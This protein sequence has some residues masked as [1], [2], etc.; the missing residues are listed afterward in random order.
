MYSVPSIHSLTCQV[1]TDSL[2]IAL[3]AIPLTGQVTGALVCTVRLV[4]NYKPYLFTLYI[5]M[6]NYAHRHRNNIIRH[7]RLTLSCTC[8]DAGKSWFLGRKMLFG[9][10]FAAISV[11]TLSILR[12]KIVKVRTQD[13]QSEGARL[14]VLRRK[15]DYLGG[16]QHAFLA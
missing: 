14:T 7:R 6:D 4:F 3:Q 10:P 11:A 13:S 9:V 1:T 12:C 2:C 16:A 5:Y 15:I 8:T